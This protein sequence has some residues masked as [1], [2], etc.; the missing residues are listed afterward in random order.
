MS[1][2]SVPV[3]SREIYPPIQVKYEGELTPENALFTID[4]TLLSTA[5]QES[6]YSKSVSS[7]V[8][9]SDESVLGEIAHQNSYKNEI[10]VYQSAVIN[11]L[12]NLRREEHE[13]LN[14]VPE[15]SSRLKNFLYRIRYLLNPM[16]APYLLLSDKGKEMHVYSGNRERRNRYRDQAQEGFEFKRDGETVKLS[17]DE[18]VAHA[19]QLFDRLLERAVPGILGWVVAHEFEHKHH[20]GRKLAI[21]VGSLFG[22]VLGVG[23]AAQA[24]G[25]PGLIGAG[26][27]L[28]Y[29][30]SIL[31]KTADEEASY[32]AGDKNFAK[33][34]KAITINHETFNRAVLTY[35]PKQSAPKG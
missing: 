21:K 5:L 34:A 9:I 12:K 16:E 27:V 26:V 32:D 6:G 7:N 22:P 3:E 20:H 28:G 4:G 10:V 18:S 29:V 11:T 23:V 8:V 13:G 25:A 2:G 15:N 31:G 35:S 24:V 14:L 30:G 17:R 33:F 1:E 19:K